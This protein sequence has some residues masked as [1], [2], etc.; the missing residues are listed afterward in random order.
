MS[1][2]KGGPGNTSKVRKPDSPQG[3][4]TTNAFWFQFCYPPVG[5]ELEKFGG[6][7]KLKIDDNHDINDCLDELWSRVL[8]TESVHNV[9]RI[10]L[11]PFASAQDVMNNTALETDVLIRDTDAKTRA[12]AIWIVIPRPQRLPRTEEIDGMFVE[13]NVPFY[14]ELL[15]MAKQEVTNQPVAKRMLEFKNNIP[16]TEIRFMYLRDSFFDL[17]TQIKGQIKKGKHL[18]SVI[19]GTPGIGKSLF[20]IYFFMKLMQKREKRV[21]LV[22]SSNIIYFDGAR[23]YAWKG[24]GNSLPAFDRRD[25]NGDPLWTEGMLFLLD[26]KNK[27]PYV[28]DGVPTRRCHTLISTSPKHGLMNE[29]KKSGPTMFFMPIWN[30]EEMKLISSKFGRNADWLY[31]FTI[32]GGVP[33]YVLEIPGE[34]DGSEPNILGRSVEEII[35]EAIGNID[36]SDILKIVNEQTIPDDNSDI[37]CHRLVHLHSSTPYRR[38]KPR[39]SSSYVIDQLCDKHLERLRQLWRE[40][41]AVYERNG[42]TGEIMGK[43]FERQAL[44]I[45]CRGGEFECQRLPA[46][47][48]KPAVR[49]LT[50]PSTETIVVTKQVGDN[51]TELLLHTPMSKKYAGID[52]WMPGVG[53]FQVTINMDHGMNEQIMKDL[54]KLKRGGKHKLYWVVRPQEFQ[55]IKYVKPS[56]FE[57]PQLEQFA[58][59]VDFMRPPEPSIGPHQ[60]HTDASPQSPTQKK[61]KVANTRSGPVPKKPKQA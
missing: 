32:L 18:N 15:E 28:L 12:G 38:A 22:Y 29:Y 34:S 1:K 3:K 54:P 31:R 17:E 19:T 37:S 55:Q 4:E 36:I 41:V 59:C 40:N 14:L 24:V 53:A 48:R 33:R 23:I 60:V 56:G 35:G 51:D 5:V 9:P 8:T 47:G 6:A 16:E 27:T 10:Q 46:K 39:F 13:C 61:R 25:P 7:Y 2:R 30:E 21:L 11:V 50:I 26:P 42:L 45:L 52:G 20:L 49:K 44:E 58:L 43:M 57:Y